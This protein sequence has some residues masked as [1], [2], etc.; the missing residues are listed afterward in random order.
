LD[1]E[2]EVDWTAPGDNGDTDS[3]DDVADSHVVEPPGLNDDDD[4]DGQP[5]QPNPSYEDE[6]IEGDVSEAAALDEETKEI[7]LILRRVRR[8]R[9]D[10]PKARKASEYCL[11]LNGLIRMSKEGGGSW[12]RI[13]D[14]WTRRAVQ[15]LL[16]VRAVVVQDHIAKE[17]R[18]PKEQ[19]TV[20]DMVEFDVLD[21]HLVSRCHDVYTHHLSDILREHHERFGKP[22]NKFNRR[23]AYKVFCDQ[24]FGK[25]SIVDCIF[26]VGHWNADL[27]E[28]YE[29]ALTNGGYATSRV[30]ATRRKEDPEPLRAAFESR[31]KA[32]YARQRFD[33]YQAAHQAPGT[34]DHCSFV[35]NY[36]LIMCMCCKAKVCSWCQVKDH[37]LCTD[38]LATRQDRVKWYADSVGAASPDGGSYHVLEADIVSTAQPTEC[39]N[40]HL[41]LQQVTKADTSL[42]DSFKPFPPW[43]KCVT[44]GRWLCRRCREKDNRGHC[45][46]CPKLQ[47]ESGGHWGPSARIP[48][49]ATSAQSV[50]ELEAKARQLTERAQEL[51]PGHAPSRRCEGL[52]AI[53]AGQYADVSQQR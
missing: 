33:R 47:S 21:N 14:D 17:R 22:G 31:K 15:N 2:E 51:F 28:M 12:T 19:V 35:E 42:P 46:D 26:R 32:R 7:M 37:V 30:G 6:R 41:T 3:C 38:C 20:R 25:K 34:C 24:W 4:I 1:P 36:G 39:A 18:V 27:T 16:L 48:R 52:G 49:N 10:D 45:L 50:A 5:S 29:N 53:V 40:C 13:S 9:R 43:A 23:G 44:C 8:R 11:P